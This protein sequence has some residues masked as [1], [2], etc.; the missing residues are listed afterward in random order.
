MAG[1]FCA[2]AFDVGELGCFFSVVRGVEVFDILIEDVLV[3]EVVFNIHVSFDA[4]CFEAGVV[5]IV[6]QF[7]ILSVSF[8]PEKLFG[9]VFSGLSGGGRGVGYLCP[10]DCFLV[11]APVD[12]ETVS[13]VIGGSFL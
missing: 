7:G 10:V 3:V 5:F 1:Y 11:E 12:D 2:D 8:S 13:L 6:W 9:G 4:G